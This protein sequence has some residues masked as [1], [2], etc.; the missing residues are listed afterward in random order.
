M[1]KLHKLAIFDLNWLY[2]FAFFQQCVRDSIPPHPREYLVWPVIFWCKLFFYILLL[3][4]CCF[5]IMFLRIHDEPFLR[6]AFAV[7]IL[8]NVWPYV[9]ANVIG[10][11]AVFCNRRTEKQQR[12]MMEFHSFLTFLALWNK[13]FFVLESSFNVFS[14]YFTQCTGHFSF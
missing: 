12:C 13:T 6:C 14:L 11:S 8:L 10:V 3:L 5:L 2:L 9:L 4:N 1:L 7:C